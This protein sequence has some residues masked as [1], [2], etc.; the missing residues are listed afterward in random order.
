MTLFLERLWAW[1]R[2]QPALLTASCVLLE[3][4]QG[5]RFL[6][7]PRLMP[8]VEQDSDHPSIAIF[9]KV[10]SKEC[11]CLAPANA[12]TAF[13]NTLRIV[14]ILRTPELITAVY[15]R[16]LLAGLTTCSRAPV[17]GD[18]PTPI[19][20]TTECFALVVLHYGNRC[21]LV[22]EVCWAA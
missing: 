19:A 4:A 22:T 12:V 14:G 6:Y 11:G 15:G 17:S 10:L 1:M 2:S 13:V 7:L 18:Q 9:Q 3:D 21:V 5:L 8:L 16:L 20:L